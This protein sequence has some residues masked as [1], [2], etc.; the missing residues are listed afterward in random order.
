MTNP[1]I[2]SRFN[3]QTKKILV[4]A[5]KYAQRSSNGVGSEHLILAML[6]VNGNL[7]FAILKEH[8]VDLKNIN[9]TI[10]T[11]ELKTNTHKGLSVELQRILEIAAKK[12]SQLNDKL[13]RPEHLLWAIT[14]DPA[15][16]AHQII[17]RSGA[18]PE[19][20]K[21]DLEEIFNQ[22]QEQPGMSEINPNGFA[23]PGMM[24]NEFGPLP[25]E[26]MPQI[27]N[28]LGVLG[29]KKPANKTKSKSATPYLDE[30]GI[31][32][33]KQAIQN[34]LDPVV[35]REKEINRAIQILCRR[36]KN[37]PV[38]IG[39][40]GVG[41]TS[42]VE[43]IA[44][45]IIQKDVPPQIQNKKI[46][47]LDI[48]TLLAGTM[49]RGQFEERLKRV[50]KEVIKSGNIIL[51]IDEIHSVVGSGSAEGSMDTANILKPQ[52]AKGQIRLIGATTVNEYRKFI[53]KDSALERRL[54]K[55]MVEE[56]SRAET[57]KILKGLKS[58]YEKHHN[59]KITSDAIESAVDLS[60]RYIFDRFLPDKAIDLIDEAASATHLTKRGAN[61]EVL[62]KLENQLSVIII[63]KEKAIENQNFELAALSRTKELRIRKEI[64]NLKS[65][66]KTQKE[67]PIIIT[68]KDIADVVSIWTKI[69]A[70]NLIES[71]K[72]KLINLDKIIKMEVVGQ[73][74]AVEEISQ[75]IKRS[76]AGIANPQR[77]LGAFMF[78]GPTG[79]GKTHLA[80]ILAQSVFGSENSLI[81][82]DMSEFMEKHS[83]SKLLGAP[84]GY[85]GYDEAGKLTE[86]VRRHPYSVVLFDEIEKAH[87][88]VFNI[89]LQIMEDGYLTDAKGKRINFRNTIIILT[90]NIGAKEL[91]QEAVIGFENE[92]SSYNLDN[93]Y[94][95]IK[96]TILG[97]LKDKMNPEF[98]N[99]LDQIIVFKPLGKKEIKKIA[100]IE[101][102]N[103]TK[104]LKKQNIILSLHD[105]VVDFIAEKSF[106]PNFGARP[107]RR[108]IVEYIENPLAEKLLSQTISPNTK[109]IALIKKE[110]IVFA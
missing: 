4:E 71:E 81:K 11:N 73:D 24:P 96:K 85:V 3:D 7:A 51:F 66:T 93:K 55:I 60:T 22:N 63:E 79:V 37:N 27:D 23:N 47:L 48:S 88:E 28:L 15:S 91:T 69:P 95:Q 14:T 6:T 43:G 68:E 17:I 84:P 104:R 34:L 38:L 75:A 110:K 21:E 80:K 77:P 97:E 72:R 25:P 45:K 70:A 92:N 50:I 39:D 103:L 40:P 9:A 52:L 94:G 46:I 26:M 35:G 33:T 62:A 8:E 10:N 76:R 29:L 100:A 2:F 5:Q 19:L 105:N 31:D 90:S 61:N 101:L 87:P 58:K 78:L 18:E 42:I 49:Y 107:I 20:I 36:T 16:M 83:V 64:F 44:Q 59:V 98:L 67:E 74:N 82:I 1:D 54:Q 106:D 12:A 102:R 109:I 56:P 89:L 32:L 41:K 30:F 86:T 53:E 108:T 65:N 57:I 13:I 99:R